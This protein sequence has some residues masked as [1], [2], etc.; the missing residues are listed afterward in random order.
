MLPASSAALMTP[1]LP[2]VDDDIFA[3]ESQVVPKDRLSMK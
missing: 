2:V 3:T 1:A